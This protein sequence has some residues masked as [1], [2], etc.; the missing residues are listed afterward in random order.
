MPDFR[1]TQIQELRSMVLGIAEQINNQSSNHELYV[2]SSVMAHHASKIIRIVSEIS[3]SPYVEGSFTKIETFTVDNEETLFMTLDENTF[4]MNEKGELLPYVLSE[5][6]L[7]S[8]TTVRHMETFL[9]CAFREDNNGKDLVIGY[10]KTKYDGWGFSN[11]G[12]NYGFYK[13]SAVLMT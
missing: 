5:Q 6:E 2:N 10:D 9:H 3:I 4:R 1:L 11:K 13:G 8:K 12:H 7:E